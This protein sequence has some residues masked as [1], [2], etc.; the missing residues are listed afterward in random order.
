MKAAVSLPP[1]QQIPLLEEAALVAPENLLDWLR[2]QVF[3]AC[4]A[5]GKYEMANAVLKPLLASQPW[6]RATTDGVTVDIEDEQM[7]EA[8]AQVSTPADAPASDD[9]SGL[10]SLT[11]AFATDAQK[12]AFELQ[13]AEMDEH[14][15]NIDS[16]MRDLESAQSLTKDAAQRQELSARVSTLRATSTRAAENA[17]RRPVI[18]DELTMTVIVRP[19]LTAPERRAP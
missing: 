17:M 3:E 13:L 8:D 11:S 7:N 19:R 14:L 5:D 9:G 1:A 16:A 15:G 18:K 6:M 12:V 10:F 2:L 4:V